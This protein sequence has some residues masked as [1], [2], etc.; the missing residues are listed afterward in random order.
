M[1]KGVN[2]QIK[3]SYH[4]A[5]ELNGY[6]VSRTPEKTWSMRGTVKQADAFRLGQRPLMFIAPHK[7][8]EWRWPIESITYEGNTV[9]ASLG[10]P[11]E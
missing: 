3:W 5:A 4:V 8:G 10:P 6:T 11:L 9:S 1:L 2:G 7:G